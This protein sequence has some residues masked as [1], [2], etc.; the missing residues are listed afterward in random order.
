MS[1]SIELF[2]V[3]FLWTYIYLALLAIIG[4]AIYGIVFRPNIL[5]KIIALTIL[6]DTANI[7]MIYVGYRYAYPLKPPILWS[8]EPTPEDISTFLAQSV[9]PLPQALVITAIVINLA[10]TLLIC[11]IAVQAYRL[12][13]S[14]DVRDLAK[15]KG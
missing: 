8:W 14:L 11:F 12:Y 10:V 2:I 3:T 9:D 5:K 4:L 6:G 7:F 15:L 13:H 1:N